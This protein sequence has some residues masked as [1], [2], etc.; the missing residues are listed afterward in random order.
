M[1]DEIAFFEPEWFAAHLERH[2]ADY[3]DARPF[4]HAVIDDFLP[5]GVAERGA[6]EFPGP[7]FPLFRQR[8]DGAHQLK[9]LGRVQEAGFREL[10]T[11]LRH[12]LDEFNGKAF[13]DFL[14]GLTG[15]PGLIGDPHFR[16]GAL[17][18]ILPGG[19][20]AIHA[21]FNWD[22]RRRLDRRVNVLFYLNRAWQ[23]EHGGELELWNEDM[24]RCEARIAPV[25]NRCVIFNTTS[26]SY[27][28]HPEPLR[29]PE[30]V[31]RKSMAFYYYTNGRPDDEKRGPHATLWQLRPEERAPK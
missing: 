6:E 9:K 11:F 30:G 3:P 27:H 16:G 8:D 5:R 13:L 31:T 21:D 29:C 20:L 14:E 2:R 28:G 25:F 15:I 1:S 17:H 23:E 19:K 7:S 10:P 12:L 24:S 4:P 18:Q 26:T 22:E